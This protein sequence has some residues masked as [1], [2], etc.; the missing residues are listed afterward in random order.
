M[1]L[2]LVPQLNCPWEMFGSFLFS[3]HGKM[4]TLL[5][6]FRS[7]PFSPCP[8]IDRHHHNHIRHQNANKLCRGL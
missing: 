2:S 1:M 7:C 8:L 3:F 4:Q 5:Y 6:H